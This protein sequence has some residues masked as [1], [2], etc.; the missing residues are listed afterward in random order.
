MSSPNPN[1]AAYVKGDALWKQGRFKE[2]AHF[3][4]IAVEEWPEDYQALWALGN[5]YTVL[6]KPR[7]AEDAFRRALDAS[8]GANRYELVFNLANTLFDQKRFEEA[9][10]LY[11]EIPSGHSLSQKAMRNAAL[12]KSRSSA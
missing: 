9:K 7:E 11:A 6:K 5:C 8:S 1:H 4:Q 3:F 2:A 12:A 10:A